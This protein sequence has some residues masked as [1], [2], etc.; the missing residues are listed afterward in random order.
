M[1]EEK[2]IIDNDN[3]DID[4]LKRIPVLEAPLR[5]DVQEIYIQENH[6]NISKETQSH[7]F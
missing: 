2:Y 7:T 1:N 3:I 5:V 4:E 6:E